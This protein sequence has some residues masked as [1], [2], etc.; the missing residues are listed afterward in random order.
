MKL[1]TILALVTLALCC[2]PTSAEICPS[3]LGA[4]QALFDGSPASYMASLEIFKPT[5]DM[6]SS[7]SQLKALVDTLSP[8]T[9]EGIRKTMK[10]FTLMLV[11]LLLRS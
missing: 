11:L 7:C 4:L 1:A 2:S 8:K 6:K 9:K 3:F 10:R 5:E